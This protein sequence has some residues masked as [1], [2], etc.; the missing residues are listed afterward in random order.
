MPCY[1]TP[2]AE[3]STNTTAAPSALC[4][5]TGR[6]LRSVLVPLLQ[7]RREGS[8]G[9]AAPALIQTRGKSFVEYMQ[10]RQQQQDENAGTFEVDTV[11]P[12]GTV[13][14]DKFACA[15]AFSLG[16][17]KSSVYEVLLP[18]MKARGVSI[19][20][21]GVTEAGLASHTTTAMQDL[22]ELLDKIRQTCPPL[23]DNDQKICLIN[24]DN[25]PNNGDVLRQHMN[26]LAAN[27]TVMTD[28][29]SHKVA[30]LNSMVDRITS[31]RE[32]DPMVPRA[33][34]VPAKALVLLDEHGDLPL[35]FATQQ[36]TPSLGLVIRRTAKEL[37]MDIALK[38]RVANGTHTAIAHAMA[39]QGLTM[40][41]QLNHHPILVEYLDALVRDQISVAACASHTASQEAVDAVWADWRSRLTHLQFGLSTFFITQN[42]AAKGG[43][44][45]GPTVRDLWAASS[46]PQ[47]QPIL[48]VTMVLAFATLLRWLTP[49]ASAAVDDGIYTGWLQGASRGDV[50][51]SKEKSASS[52]ETVHYADGLNHNLKEGWYE[53]RCACAVS[54]VDAV[55]GGEGAPASSSSSVV[56]SVSEWLGSFASAQQPAAYVPIIRAYLT[57]ETGGN[58][59]ASGTSAQLDALAQAIATLYA[60]MVAGDGIL[61]MLQEMKEKSG[62]FTAGMNTDSM[63]LL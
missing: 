1:W 28:F 54:V 40:T 39:L 18:R 13:Q 31:H 26:T 12:N 37:Q 62:S 43:I 57:A 3:S 59:G 8:S 24:T 29:L 60:R 27:D 19:L 9:S 35:W 50:G 56:K 41:D 34:P 32:G 36:K 6:F 4:V 15:G 21:V 33:E 14:T 11:L 48:T 10:H 63:M 17:D 25:V 52:S 7:R 61:E 22:Y 53:F 44:R 47:P 23:P 42:G 55:G 49:A 51:T 20:G 5:G 38:L 46:T 45:L 16:H 2:D 30:F 58:L